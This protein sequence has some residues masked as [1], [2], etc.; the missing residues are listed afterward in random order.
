MHSYAEEIEWLKHK[1]DEN[2]ASMLYARLAE[3]YLRIHE[4]ERAV[5]FAEKSVVLH[6]DYPTGRFVLAKC[7]FE[8]KQYDEAHK[9]LREAL[10]IDPDYI[11]ALDLQS[12]LLRNLG[13]YEKVES[14]YNHILEID[15]IDDTVHQKISELGQDAPPSDEFLEEP[16]HD[17][18]ISG[19]LEEDWN[20][21]IDFD[22]AERDR[23][24]EIPQPAEEPAST[25]QE[26][27]A[28]V[29]KNPFEDFETPAVSEEEKPEEPPEKQDSYRQDEVLDESIDYDF[30]IDPSKYQEEESKFTA[31]L[32]TIFS[33][34]IDEEEQREKEERH[35][36]ERIVSEE[37]DLEESEEEEESD[38]QLPQLDDF[39]PLVPPDE[40]V[41]PEEKILQS[42]L[43]QKD[44]LLDYESESETVAEEN[45]L[46]E[47]FMTFDAD[48]EDEV[49][50]PQDVELEEEPPEASP[51]PKEEESFESEFSDFLS[52]L[53][54]KEESVSPV[55]EPEPP[56]P[57]MPEEPKGPSDSY[58][59]SDVTHPDERSAFW[60]ESPSEEDEGEPED[61]H[62]PPEP[63]KPAEE[64]PSDKAVSKPEDDQSRGKFYTPTLGEIYAA[65]GQ[66]S[67]AISVYETLIKNNPDNEWYKEKLDY[68]RQK[69]EEQQNQ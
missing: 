53:D 59:F 15:P 32:D 48:M 45:S 64:A 11:S 66:Y 20:P 4:V 61:A 1:V 47:E 25:L 35:A 55:Q 23:D 19:T 13:D 16:Q 8:R 57:Q 34:S 52:S 43:E 14:N 41:T 18:D 17:F 22:A 21:D 5:E 51:E 29:D 28:E 62:T 36:I 58:D 49:E 56:D 67:K 65:Q 7:F 27:E 6:P 31:L 40:Q 9:N 3:R 2:P 26:P 42:E 50:E 63:R 54:I 44:E 24:V 10:S 33:S 39:E 37:I 60:D 12:E 38:R 30:E 69:L 46:P 68:L